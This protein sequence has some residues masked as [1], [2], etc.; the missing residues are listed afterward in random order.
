MDQMVIFQMMQAPIHTIQIETIYIENNSKSHFSPLK[1]TARIQSKILLH[2]IPAIISVFAII[3]SMILLLTFTELPLIAVTYSCY[4]A[5]FLLYFAYLEAMYP[6]KTR[7]RRL[8]KEL[9][10]VA[11][12]MCTCHLMLIVTIALLHWTH[13]AMVPIA[14]LLSS[15]L[16]VL[17]SWL[18]RKIFPSF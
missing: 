11:I 2:A 16:N 4:T 9:L 3:A 10:F 13:Y 8:L 12:K 6:T 18:L 17:M 7:L 5:A 14:V 15:T 1:D